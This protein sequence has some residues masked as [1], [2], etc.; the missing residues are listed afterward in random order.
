MIDIAPMEI[1]EQ[2]CPDLVSEWQLGMKARELSRLASALFAAE[3]LPLLARPVQP[4]D[5]HTLEA[6]DLIHV[7]YTLLMSTQGFEVDEDPREL[8]NSQWV[9]VLG[10]GEEGLT[11]INSDGVPSSENA[12]WRDHYVPLARLE[13]V[14]QGPT[15]E[16]AYEDQAAVLIRN[17]V[18]GHGKN[19][20]TH[21]DTYTPEHTE[22]HAHSHT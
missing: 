18:A 19:T 8:C 2:H 11:I 20:P 12:M 7:N 21:T 14:W 16:G 9:T 1:V 17:A 5:Y 15:L 22:T 4:C 10:V 3:C 6:G 13:E